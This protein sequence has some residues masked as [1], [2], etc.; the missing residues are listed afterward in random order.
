[1]KPYPKTCTTYTLRQILTELDLPDLPSL[2]FRHETGTAGIQISHVLFDELLK[3]EFADSIWMYVKT[4]S[5]MIPVFNYS[6]ENPKPIE[7]YVDME[8]EVDP[9]V[10][11]EDQGLWCT[12]KG[13]P[14]KQYYYRDEKG[15]VR[16][17]YNGSLYNDYS[18][19]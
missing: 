4:T 5:E 13:F 11:I 2:N 6:R 17:S 10:P 9:Y 14:Q 16:R 8:T 3:T 7:D 18:M 19:I 12:P 15:V 1:M